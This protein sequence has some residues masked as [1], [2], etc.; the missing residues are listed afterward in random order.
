MICRIYIYIYHISYVYIIYIFNMY[1]Y[2]YICI[3]R[4]L[5]PRKAGLVLHKS[6]P[7]MLR[8]THI[9]IQ[10]PSMQHSLDDAGVIYIYKNIMIYMFRMSG[11]RCSPRRPI[12]MPRGGDDTDQRNRTGCKHQFNSKVCYQLL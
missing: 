1:T 2:M 9:T 3:Y 8:L 5:Y 12:P 11:C 4:Y 10:F 6:M 7:S